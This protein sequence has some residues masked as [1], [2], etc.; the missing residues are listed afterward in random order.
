M[1]MGKKPSDFDF[2]TD[3]SPEEV[4]RLF[5]RVVPTG[6]QHGTVTVLHKNESYEVTTFRIEGDYSDA[7]RPDNVEY[8]SDIFEDLKRRDFTINA[9][10][11]NLETGEFLDPFQGK[12]DIASRVIRAIGNPAER[13]NEDALRILRAFRFSAQLSFTI[14][15]ETFSGIVDC[16]EKLYQVSAE[17]IRDEL[18]KIIL[19]PTPSK[20]LQQMEKAGVLPI[21]L[22]ELSACTGVQQKG[23]HQY[24]VFEHSFYSCDAVPA[25]KKAVRFAAL[26]HDIGKVETIDYDEIGVVTFYQHEKTSVRLTRNIMRRLKFPRDFEE[27]VL[28]LIAN[29]MFHYEDIWTDA[30][31]RR[32]IAK[33]GKE[34]LDDLFLLRR[35]DQ[36]G[37]FGKPIDPVN[38]KAFRKHIDKVL[39]EAHALKIA[40]LAVNGHDLIKIGIPKGPAIGIVLRELLETVID[41]PSQNSRPILLTIATNFYKQIS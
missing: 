23:L 22:P 37:T 9:M 5:R 20:G 40:D 35:A 18:E 41:D 33:V 19:S 24:D 15:P 7:R 31:V 29:H 13:F 2:A 16:K 26:F 32:F 4:I 38:L 11:I 39:A 28:H 27:Q 10:A 17:R 30:A 8:T 36:Y 1:V 14:D 25:E 21:V 34:Y 6:I 12:K 3:A